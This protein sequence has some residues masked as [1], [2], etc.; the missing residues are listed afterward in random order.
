MLY[1]NFTYYMFEQML[2]HNE[3]CTFSF[4]EILWVKKKR[5]GSL[6]V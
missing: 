2:L 6:G 5:V 4:R 3:F 1:I